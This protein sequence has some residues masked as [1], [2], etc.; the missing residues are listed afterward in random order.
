MVPAADLPLSSLVGIQVWFVPPPT[1]LRT[2]RISAV[3]EGPKGALVT[4]EGVERIDLAETLRD[5][6][7]L[8]RQGD[9][10][11]LPEP[12][13]DPVGLE[14]IDAERGSLGTV[15]E[16]IV[17][18]ANDVW[19]VEG[20]LGEVLLP[21]ID[22]VVLEIDDEARVASVRLLPGLIDEVST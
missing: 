16:L 5:A 2:S 19:V 4:L 1:S 7:L 10:P 17:T 22:D 20:P 11:Q 12:A 15:Q 18:G 21:V 3:R 14:V 13:F 9:I 6:E 8:A